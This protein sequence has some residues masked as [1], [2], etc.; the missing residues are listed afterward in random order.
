MRSLRICGLRGPEK[1]RSTEDLVLHVRARAAG[2]DHANAQATPATDVASNRC[3][4]YR[5]EYDYPLTPKP[6]EAGKPSLNRPRPIFQLFGGYCIRP[7]RLVPSD[8]KD[9]GRTSIDW[10]AFWVA[11]KGFKSSCHNPETILF[12]IY[13]YC[14]NLNSVP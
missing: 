4:Y 11:V 7:R 8:P 2:R 9:S 14:G 5:L 3:R 13:P 6:R 1:L 10:R 12:A